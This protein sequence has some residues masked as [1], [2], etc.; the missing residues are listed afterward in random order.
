MKRHNLITAL[1]LL[2][3]GLTTSIAH[4]KPVWLTSYQDALNQ[5]KSANKLVLINFTGSDWCGWCIK[6]RKEVFATADF[7][8]YANANFVLLEADFPQV[9]KLSPEQ[10][11][12]NE[13][14]AR[15]FRIEGYP[16]IIVTDSQGR[17]VGQSGYVPGGPK[18]F[19]ASLQ[20]IKGLKAAE[21]TEAPPPVAV[22]RSPFTPPPVVAPHGS[23]APLVQPVPT[24]YD[25]LS[26][27]G[28]TGP[29]SR[30]IALINNQT[31][32]S[33]EKARTK[34]GDKTVD[35]VCLEIRDDS[36][37]VAVE[38]RTEPVELKLGA[39]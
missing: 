33:G 34:L 12:A 3:S 13:N 18:A 38:N 29:K 32:L 28:I 7:E 14:L 36:V 26:L 10:T 16:T 21:W 24:R 17:K 15:Q 19:A 30:R 4:A 1:V 22:T 8:A 2:F 39:K 37:L 6:L 5:A 35:V 11:R 20:E 25:S 23:Q 31:F 27:K 9:K